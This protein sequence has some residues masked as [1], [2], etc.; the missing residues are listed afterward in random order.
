M[1]REYS[2]NNLKTVVNHGCSVD[3]IDNA[4]YV[5]PPS[6]NVFC[7]NQTS[8][9]TAKDSIVDASSSTDYSKTHLYTAL[10]PLMVSLKIIG[11]HHVR[12]SPSSPVLKT[13]T[14][15]RVLPSLMQV[16]CC[17][18]VIFYWFY[19]AIDT[20]S[21]LH[22]STRNDTNP[23]MRINNIA[24]LVWLAENV[25]KATWF[26]CASQWMSAL[27]KV[28][29]CS[30]QLDEFGGLKTN[31]VR[32]QRILTIICLAFW[33]SFTCFLFVFLYLTLATPVF[34]D[35]VPN[36]FNGNGN[37]ASPLYVMKV[38]YCL[39]TIFEL[40]QW[41]LLLVFELTVAILIS[42]EF[43]RFCKAFSDKCDAK[44]QFRGCLE[45]ERRHFAQLIRVVEAADRSL[46]PYHAASFGCNIVI[47]CLIIYNLVYYPILTVTAWAFSS[48]ILWILAAF[49]DL[50][51]VCI[52]GTL[53][54]SS[55]SR[56]RLE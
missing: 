1:I 27:R 54:S 26:V 16:F 21:L 20:V 2:Q 5:L 18:I 15:L 52:S 40:P 6:E 35:V 46:A 56:P 55:V 33:I 41:P 32:V 50:C 47:L 36:A 8:A 34:D 51:V 9:V 19:L 13:A 11:L 53:V 44:G 49:I 7:H 3:N 37:D 38:L 23:Y 39:F 24:F 42:N 25:F 10:K 17:A 31:L 45:L 4:V 12:P 14:S 28:F 22:V 30:T 29:I 48:Y 43:R